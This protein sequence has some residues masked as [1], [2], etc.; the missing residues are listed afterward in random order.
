MES[1]TRRSLKHKGLLAI[2]CLLLLAISVSC[3]RQ[4]IYYHFHEIKNGEWS[5]SDTLIFDI[6]TTK[7]ELNVPYT[8][9]IEVTNN[10]NYPYQNIWFFIQNN[11]ENDSVFVKQEKEYMLADEFGKWKG[12]GFGTLHQLSLALDN[13]IVFKEKRNYRIK[14]EHGMRDKDLTGIEK[15]GIRISKKD[16]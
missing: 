4:D 15:V 12:S 6:D 11:F 5:Y 3:N 10:V 14:I 13:N 7:F 2:C 8:M 16:N 9:D 1:L